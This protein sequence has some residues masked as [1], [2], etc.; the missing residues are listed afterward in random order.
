MNFLDDIERA[1]DDGVNVFRA[2]IFDNRFVPGAGSSETILATELEAK[3][4]TFKDL[5]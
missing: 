1:I 3:A 4:K 5:N 2:S